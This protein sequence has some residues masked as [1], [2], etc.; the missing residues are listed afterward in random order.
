MIPPG[1][2]GRDPHLLLASAGSSGFRGSPQEKPSTAPLPAAAPPPQA[3]PR[4]PP[5]PRT[6]PS[7]CT[8]SDR[9][10]PAYR[11]HQ[12]ARAASPALVIAV[13][14]GTMRPPTPGS[15]GKRADQ[16]RK[17][18]IDAGLN[19]VEKSRLARRFTSCRRHGV[20]AVP[21][22]WASPMPPAR[23]C[24]VPT[25]RSSAAPTA[26]ESAVRCRHAG[27]PRADGA[28]GSVVPTAHTPRRP[29]APSR[30]GAP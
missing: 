22:A 8:H 12:P 6:R 14:S 15:N 29:L 27:P 23:G 30:P 21:T 19:G 18:F 3:S 16:S 7:G 17:R 4:A 26:R 10:P 11:T 20:I 24:R 28:S 5:P 2:L 25:V 13:Q 1:H 9:S